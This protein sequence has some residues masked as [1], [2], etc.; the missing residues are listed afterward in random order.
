MPS[1]HHCDAHVSAEFVRVFGDADGEVHACT[2]CAPNA[3][4]GEVTL[5]RAREA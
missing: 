5:T 4:I 3:G 1:C 2:A